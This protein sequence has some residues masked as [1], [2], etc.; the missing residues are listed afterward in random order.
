MTLITLPAVAR[1][2]GKSGKCV[3]P[4][5]PHPPITG[6]IR[7]VRCTKITAACEPVAG[8]VFVIPKN[9]FCVIA[10]NTDLRLLDERGDPIGER[11]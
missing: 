2:P 1:M 5:Q 10:G 4:P 3:I 6:K 8:H 11:E 9:Q 7:R